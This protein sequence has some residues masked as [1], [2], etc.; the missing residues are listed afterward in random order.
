MREGAVVAG[1]D[2]SLHTFFPVAI[3]PAEGDA[4]RNWI[5]RERATRTIEIGLGYGISAL[6]ACEGLLANGGGAHVAIDPHQ[7]TRFGGCGLQLL[8]DAG[9]ADLVEH[10]AEESQAALPRFLAEGRRF[11]LAFVDGNHRFD[12]VFVDLFFLGRLLGPGGIVVLDDY[13]LRAVRRAASFFATN[14]EWT[15][16]ETSPPDQQHQWAVFRTPARPDA[17]DYDHFV[18]F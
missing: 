15:L 3:S 7:A 17:R 13:Q 5:V 2:G 8:E 1:S 11:D 18:D 14:V 10:H 4:L 16:E 9:V 12:Y 6:Y